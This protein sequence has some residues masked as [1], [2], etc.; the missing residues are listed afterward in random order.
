MNRVQFR[1]YVADKLKEMRSSGEAWLSWGDRR[2]RIVPIDL[3]DAIYINGTSVLF[4][5][6]GDIYW[7]SLWDTDGN[8]TGKRHP[9]E[10]APFCPKTYV[11][12]KKILARVAE[13][14]PR[15]QAIPNP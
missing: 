3:D 12:I 6:R 5:D 1:Q 4:K 2:I 9:N 13:D 10:H 14:H 11:Q 15:E 8:R 7:E